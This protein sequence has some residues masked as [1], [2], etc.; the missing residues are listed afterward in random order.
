ME[1]RATSLNGNNRGEEDLEHKI[2]TF[3]VANLP[4]GCTAKDLELAYKEYGEV[5]RTFVAP[6]KDKAGRI[7]GFVDFMGEHAVEYLVSTLKNVT[8]LG[9]SVFIKQARFEKGALPPPP[10]KNPGDT[11][12]Q[13]KYHFDKNSSLF[14]GKSFASVLSGKSSD[15][16]GDVDINIPNNFRPAGSIL[17]SGLVGRVVDFTTL[18]NFRYITKEAG[19]RDFELK[20]LGGLYLLIHF[21]GSYSKKEFLENQTQWRKWFSFLD[22]WTGQ[23][24][25]FERIAW[26]RIY[27][28]PPHLWDR[29]VFDMVGNKFGKVVHPSQVSWNDGNW[30][31]DC[32]GVLKEEGAG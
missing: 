11:K 13:P 14:N 8:I 19:I 15:Y 17:G 28:V 21:K 27:G 25:P 31:Y 1:G 29:A 22:D 18:R 2:N 16:W 7:F 5:T 23:S 3:F 26:L 12:R 30:T 9:K 20:Y 4:N 6:K 10:S 32:I 24:L